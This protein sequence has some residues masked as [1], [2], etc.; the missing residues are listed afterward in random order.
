MKKILFF[1]VIFVSVIMAAFIGCS[2]SPSGS[3]SGSTTSPASAAEVSSFVSNFTSVAFWMSDLVG[4][5]S[6]TG[7][8]IYGP[9][10]NVIYMVKETTNGL[11]EVADDITL[12]FSNY[13]EPEVTPYIWNG[14]LSLTNLQAPVTNDNNYSTGSSS[15]SGLSISGVQFNWN[16]KYNDFSTNGS[17]VD[18]FTTSGT[19]NGGTFSTN[20]SI[21]FP[22]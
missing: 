21:I 9:G 13:T 6:E 11:G 15:G 20:F 1:Q 8:N 22:D 16:V 18:Y 12:I 14:D 10:S 19:I 7:T 17:S 5:G 2:A 4:Q 3:G